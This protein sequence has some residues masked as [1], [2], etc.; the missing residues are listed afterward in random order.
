MIS[1]NQSIQFDKRRTLTWKSGKING[2]IIANVLLLEIGSMIFI[3][4]LPADNY[5]NKTYNIHIRISI[6][7][8]YHNIFEIYI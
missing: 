6:I 7:R 1:I 4:R 3:Y 8:I 2:G 5:D